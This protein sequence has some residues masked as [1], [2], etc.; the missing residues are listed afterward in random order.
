[1]TT[2]D[3]ERR[4]GRAP[5]A[6]PAAALVGVLLALVL[7]VVG[8]VGVREALRAAGAI[9]GPHWMV[10]VANWIDGLA[11]ATWMIPAGVGAVVL[12]LACVLA[13]VKPRRQTEARVAGPGSIWIRPRGISRVAAATANSVA[14]TATA[15]AKTGRRR[16]TV[17]ITATEAEAERLRGEVAAAVSEALEPL[18]RTVSVRVKAKLSHDGAEP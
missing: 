9:A 3:D 11:P 15:S 7:I 17:T 5:V 13:A 6:A 18:E 16:V 12:G 2:T 1:M 8:A 14:G 4:L 10:N